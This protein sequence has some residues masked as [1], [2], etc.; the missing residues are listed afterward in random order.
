MSW[1][2]GNAGASSYTDLL[3]EMPA[4]PPPFEVPASNGNAAA[5]GNSGTGFAGSQFSAQ[6]T[7]ASPPAGRPVCACEIKH[8]LDSTFSGRLSESD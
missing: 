1:A 7:P 4:V 5:N 2:Q 8:T 3:S 6:Q